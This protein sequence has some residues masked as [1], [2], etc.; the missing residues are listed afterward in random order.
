MIAVKRIYEK[1]ESS[2]GY[3]ILLHYANTFR[4]SLFNAK[5]LAFPFL[6]YHN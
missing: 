5:K 1:P 2:D 3:R 4:N 6:Y